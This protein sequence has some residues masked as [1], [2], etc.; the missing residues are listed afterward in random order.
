MVETVANN[1]S[2]FVVSSVCWFKRT[3]VIHLRQA[4]R[5]ITE[6]FGKCF[7]QPQLFSFNQFGK[8]F[9]VTEQDPRME[10][11]SKFVKFLLLLQKKAQS[12]F[13]YYKHEY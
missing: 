12:K 10:I 9:K 7:D 2:C 11:F 5:V 6:Q 8:R 3:H 4:E 1:C 13:Q